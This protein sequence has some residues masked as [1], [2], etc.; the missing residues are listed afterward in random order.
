MSDGLDVAGTD[1]GA[2]LFNLAQIH[3]AV[4]AAIPDRP[5]VIFGDT[6]VTYA[7]LTDQSRRF[8]SALRS[9]GLGT[10]SDRCALQ[11]HESG[12]DHLA[13]YLRNEPEYLVGMLGA[14]KARLAPL[15]VNYRYIAEELRHVLADGAAKA[16]LFQD[17]FAPAL[18]AVL[19]GL[20]QLDLLI[21]V[22]DASGHALLPGAIRYDDF[23]AAGSPE[24]LEIEWS[25]S[26]LYILYTGGTTGLPKGVLWQQHDV[27]LAAM[28]GRRYG[29]DQVFGSIP[30]IVE[31]ATAGGIKLMILGPL[32]HGGAQWASF[33][34]FTMGNTIVLAD[35]PREF[36]PIG[37]LQTVV[38]ERVISL[39]IVGDVMARP[40]V[41]E[42]E[43]GDY[44]LSGLFAV[45]SGGVAFTAPLQ[46]RFLAAVPHA[47]V[48]DGVGSSEGGVQM[49]S[50]AS[51]GSVSTGTFVPGRDTT[52]LRADRSGVVEP[53]TG[54][55]GWLT[56]QGNVPIGYLND[57]VKT[58]NTFP[59]IDAVRYSIPGD[60]AS[61]ALD[62]A[63]QLLG[64]DSVTINSGGEKI[65][66]EDVERA[67][68]AHPAVYDVVV[69]GR[70][71]ER[72]GSEVVAIV[73]RV[74]GVEVTETELLAEAGKHIA[75]Y[76]LPKAILFR[77]DLP[78]SPSGKADYRWAATVATAAA[79]A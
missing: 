75:R 57:P 26:D 47:I 58:A 38:R 79:S 61:L 18:A 25:P 44:D 2:T 50:T 52:V 76:K 28:G 70:P 45:A 60:R 13:I 71:S 14:F 5:A 8:A 32:M 59:V 68:S 10:V 6:T 56:R 65:F 30:E 36:D 31:G 64:R 55:L 29:T 53:G 40:L 67:L 41:E 37:I 21:Q 43:R 4:S 12:Q 34:C 62:G 69:V 46:E 3:E 24:P 19:P 49:G 27:F 73:R 39:Q 17:E 20:P 74:N 15:N 33:T 48:R 63:I 42:I 16:V 66:A 54:E 77:D 7:D 9:R 72:W 22:P 35:N 11:G 78:R 23:L 51:K 1:A